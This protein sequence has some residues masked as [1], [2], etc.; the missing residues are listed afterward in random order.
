MVGWCEKVENG[1]FKAEK[2]SGH[3][4]QT[5]TWLDLKLLVGFFFLFTA[6]FSTAVEVLKA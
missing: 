3:L 6:S 2:W 4:I 1:Q 5:D